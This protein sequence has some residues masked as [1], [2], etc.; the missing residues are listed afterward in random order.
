[1]AH[2]HILL[3]HNIRTH[4]QHQS[5]NQS[6]TDLSDNLELAVHPFLILAE[7]LDIIVSKTEST[8]PDGRHH[9]QDYINIVQL[10]AKQCRDQN[11][12]DNN[13]TSHCRRTF[14]THL[15]FQS[16]VTHGFTDLQ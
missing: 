9:H 4:K 2:F 16:E 8:Q 15:P 7:D 3:Y 5:D 12:N 11:G 13:D 1:M 14:L 6:Q 10:G